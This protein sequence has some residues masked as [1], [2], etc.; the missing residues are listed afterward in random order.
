MKE[1]ILSREEV[2][3]ALTVPGLNVEAA[4]EPRE[5]GLLCG[6]IIDLVEKLCGEPIYQARQLSDEPDRWDDV[7]AGTHYAC[8]S[9]PQFYDTRIV[10]AL[11]RSQS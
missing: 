8:A 4:L 1:P 5:V 11:N 6:A 9:Q 10:Y 7:Y 3:D 2:L